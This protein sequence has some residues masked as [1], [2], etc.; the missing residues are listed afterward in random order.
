MDRSSQ[1]TSSMVA[2]IVASLAAS[3]AGATAIIW[4][5]SPDE[6]GGAYGGDWHNV[7]TSQNFASDVR[8]R[9]TALAQY[10][11]RSCQSKT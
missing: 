4:D 10:S 5:Q 7:S 9:I 11:C 8:F 1:L 2:T 3:P 6:L